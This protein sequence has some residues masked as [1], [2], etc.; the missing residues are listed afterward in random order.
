MGYFILVLIAG[1]VI[2]AFYDSY[3]FIQYDGE[4]KRGIKIGSEFLSP[5][6]I[7]HLRKLS[8]D[9]VSEE[10]KAFIRKQNQIVL[11]QPIASTF[12]RNLGFWYIGFVDLSARRTRINYH[13]P[14]S[15][16]V[17]LAL[18]LGSIIFQVFN[19]SSIEMIR[20]VFVLVFV[21]PFLGIAHATS[22]RVVKKYIE[23]TVQIKSG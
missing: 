4:M 5:E 8:S 22:K 2:F 3:R 12:Q 10:T 9:V 17:I 18:I 20:A 7:D 14:I 19:G 11:I 23:S 13:T 1:C 6:I 21:T 15:A 16:V